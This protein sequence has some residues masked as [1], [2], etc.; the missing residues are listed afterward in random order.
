MSA[1]RRIA[2]TRS[3][4][5]DSSSASTPASRNAARRLGLAPL[6]GR[7]EAL[8]EAAVVGVDEELLAGLGVLHHQHAEVGQLGLERV[9]QPHRDHLVALREAA[10]RARPSPA[11]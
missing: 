1:K 6:R 3:S 7:G 4:S 10:E 8:A 5:V 11:R 2:S 9:V